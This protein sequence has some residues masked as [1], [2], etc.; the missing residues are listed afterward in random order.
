MFFVVVFVVFISVETT[1]VPVTVRQFKLYQT[2]I[3]L[4][5]NY[6]H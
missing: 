2:C 6:S 1:I 3:V 4:Y 5:D